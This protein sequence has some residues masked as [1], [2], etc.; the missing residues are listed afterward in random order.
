MRRYRYPAAL[1]GLL[2]VVA[3]GAFGVAR[4]MKGGDAAH[5]AAAQPASPP[6]GPSTSPTPSARS[7]EELPTN[8]DTSQPNWYVPYLEAARK[9]P[10][11]NQTINGILVGPSAEHVPGFICKPG[12]PHEVPLQEAAGT[13]VMIAPQYLPA[14]TTQSAGWA[15]ACETVS[16]EKMIVSADVDYSVPSDQRAGRRGGVVTIS[17]WFG[18]PSATVAIP[19]ERW[20]S[21]TV[22]GHQAAIARPILPNG[23]G[24]SA[25]VVYANG[26]ITK[27][28]AAWLPLE[29]ARRIAEGLYE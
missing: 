16:G 27:V 19:A 8:P 23:L 3:A 6:Q 10:A 17:R 20:F 4:E 1:A 14:G 5:M 15:T 24:E 29:E 2:V 12:T 25:V 13:P 28:Q 26:V 7:L 11:L 21:G 22:A 18:E 9:K